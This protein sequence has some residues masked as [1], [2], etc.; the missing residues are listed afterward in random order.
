MKLER[1]KFLAQLKTESEA[2]NV[3][4]VTKKN[5]EFLHFLTRLHKA[6]LVLEIGTANGYSTIWFADAIE[7]FD[8][9]VTTIDHSTPSRNWA[10]ENFK[11]VGLEDRITS[12]FG[13]AQEVL[14]TLDQKFD[15]IFI[16]AIKKS[17]AEFWQLCKPLMHDNTLIIVD[18]VLKF[19]VKTKSFHEAI[20][21]ETDYQAVIVPTD[22]DDGIMLIQKG[23]N[24]GFYTNQK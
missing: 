24:T 1:I 2:D 17:Y 7:E 14:P 18:D 6:K 23:D 9:H 12:I 21:N 3:P 20:A 5:A 13:R 10:L 19:P 8:G 15:V 4:N 22:E 16:D 11:K